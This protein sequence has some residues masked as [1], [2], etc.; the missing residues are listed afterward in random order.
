MSS[1]PEVLQLFVIQCRQPLLVWCSEQVYAQLLRWVPEHV[2]VQVHQQ[3]AWEPLE[4]SC[5]GFYH[6]A[7]PGTAPSYS[8]AQLLRTMVVKYVYHWSPRQLEE[9][10]R[11]NL[12]VKWFCGYALL[13]PTPD[14]CTSIVSTCG[15]VSSTPGCC[16]RRSSA[17]L[18]LP[19]PG[20]ASK[21]SRRTP[22]PCRPMP[23]KKT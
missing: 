5:A 12:L 18:M 10:L 13:A 14:H 9:Q 2:L 22:L 16:L 6:Q 17:R 23:P 3:L 4:T 20:S 15:W 8:V 1:L 21:R 11:F 19:G 7:G